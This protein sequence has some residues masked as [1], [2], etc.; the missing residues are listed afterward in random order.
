MKPLFLLTL[1]CLAAAIYLIF[2]E[3][4]HLPTLAGTRALLKL[5]QAKKARGFQA[6]RLR[7][8]AGLAKQIHLNP[9]QHR[10][11]TA[12]LKYAG[13]DLSPEAYYANAIVKALFRLLPSVLCVFTLPVG[14]AV[15]VLWALKGYFNGI[16]EAQNV[17]RAKREKID[18]ELP[19]F[20]STISQEL[21]ASRDV[22][23]LL[24]GYLP[25]AGP[26]FRDELKITVAEMKSGSREQA[27]NH[28]AGRVGS[29]MLSQVVRGLLGVL[30]GG[31]GKIYF[32]MLAH[33][34][35]NVNR[36]FLKKEALKR[37]GKLKKWSY[38]MLGA[39]SAVYA[40]VI[41]VQILVST[42]SMWG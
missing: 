3:L 8:S 11:M 5:T 37:P 20:V 12:T 29:A 18:A 24:E 22:L 13:I 36:Q 32:G 38:L 39:F 30:R 31:D 2:C 1:I 42:K 34:F 15:F 7:L 41:I 4:L 25:S 19:R 33:D 21:E 17:V 35:E 40:Y 26:L 6:V 16:R 28:L 9:Y 27:L 14:I 10:T 23:A